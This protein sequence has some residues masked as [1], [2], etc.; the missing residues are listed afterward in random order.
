[1][2]AEQWR[3]S[4]RHKPKSETFMSFYSQ[5]ELVCLG[6][7]RLGRGVSLSRKASIYNA[8]NIEIGDFSRIDDF[9]VL[10]AGEGGIFIGRH[11]HVAIYCSLI[12]NGMIELG[13]YSGLSSRVSIYSS[14]DDYSGEFMTNPNCA[15]RFHPCNACTGPDRPS[16]HYRC[17][18][19]CPTRCYFAR[20]RRGGR[21]V[22]GQAGLRKFRDVLWFTGPASGGA[23]A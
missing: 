9:C 16:C 20:R 21:V 6:F 2:F 7:K 22:T 8:A 10:S 11:V 15:I 23:L 5:E 12:G 13:D 17:R 3:S 18:L 14:N 1:M 4:E 19:D